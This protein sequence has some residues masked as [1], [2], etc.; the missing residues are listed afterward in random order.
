MAAQGARS[1]APGRAKPRASGAKQGGR[2]ELPY[3]MKDLC[4]RTGLPR[5]VVHFYIQQG[6]LPEGRKTGRN[7]AWY[8]EQHVERLKLI[9]QLQEE[10]FLPLKAIRAMLDQRDEAFTPRQRLLI[11]EVRQRLGGALGSNSPRR[12]VTASE[13][14]RRSGVTPAEL[15]RM[16]KLGLLAVREE[17]GRTLL[18]CDDTYILE[19]WGQLKAAGFTPEL[20]F[21]VDDLAMYQEA[22]AGLLAREAQML[23]TRLSELPPEQAAGMVERALPIVNAFLARAHTTQVRDFLASH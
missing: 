2:D 23:G 11:S 12:T 19:L 15:A 6:L 14:L 13:V 4:E 9:R 22:L 8:G 10:R 17:D 5:Q 21:T 16:V 3:R 1:R 20:G 18:S 7:M